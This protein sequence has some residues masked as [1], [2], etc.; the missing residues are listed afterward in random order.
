MSVGYKTAPFTRSDKFTELI[1]RPV[2]FS[3]IPTNLDVHPNTSDLIR[4]TNE[5]SIKKQMRNLLLTDK[6]ERVFLPSYGCSIR[7]ILF[8]NLDDQTALVVKDLI[9]EAVKNHMPH[10]RVLAVK[11]T[12]MDQGV[13]IEIVFVALNIEGDQSFS[14]YL[15]R[16]R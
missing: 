1:N 12:G 13:V 6:Y 11:V 16:V 4:I 15:E 8:E 14:F 3:D 9:T 10:V 7:S 2:K 5:N